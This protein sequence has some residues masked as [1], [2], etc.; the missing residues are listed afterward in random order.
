MAERSPDLTRQRFPFA[1]KLTMTRSWPTCA[2]MPVTPS[3]GT[4]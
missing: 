4:R 3:P 2:S 1:R